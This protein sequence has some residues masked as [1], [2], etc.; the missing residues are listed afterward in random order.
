[1]AVF[2]KIT[3]RVFN[4][5][6][7]ERMIF[8]QDEKVSSDGFFVER[9]SMNAWPGQGCFSLHLHFVNL[10]RFG[11]SALSA[12]VYPDVTAVTDLNICEAIRNQDAPMS[13]QRRRW[14]A[15]L[16]SPWQGP[17]LRARFESRRQGLPALKSQVISP[18]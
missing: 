10:R 3:V 18:P 5:C 11:Q 13:T 4:C 14:Q 12:A 1:M 15:S 2:E 8:N 17:E 9:A 7:L 6:V 16:E